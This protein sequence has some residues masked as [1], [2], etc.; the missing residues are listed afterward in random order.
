MSPA[1][2]VLACL[3]CPPS[4]VRIR[5]VTFATPSARRS[6]ASSRLRCAPTI[7]PGTL[8]LFALAAWL[9]AWTCSWSSWTS[10]SSA[11][12][13]LASESAEKSGWET[14]WTDSWEIRLTSRL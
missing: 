3:A 2:V 8:R 10:T 1:I 4:A 5:L 6:S 11:D 7:A 13:E 9:W 14:C 12:L